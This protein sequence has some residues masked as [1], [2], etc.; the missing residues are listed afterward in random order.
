MPELTPDEKSMTPACNTPFELFFDQLNDLYSLEIQ[1]SESMPQLITLCTNEKLQYL[2]VSHAQQ[3]LDQISKI[4]AIFDHYEKAPVS[5]KC[6]AMA[7]LIE[8]GTMHIEGAQCPHT[9][10]LMMIGHCLRIEYYEMAA[11]EMTTFLSVR[12][13]LKR[14]LPILRHLLSEEKDM[15]AALQRL[16]PDL[17]KVAAPRC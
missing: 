11:Y 10:N 8:G 12:L 6:K 17:L 9:R 16:E 5:D 7:G 1:L 14:E 13:K 2:I 4:I 15:A 3:N